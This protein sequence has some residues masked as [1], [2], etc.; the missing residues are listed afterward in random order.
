MRMWKRRVTT[1]KR[2]K[3]RTCTPRPPVIM[4]CAML[5]LD[6][7]LAWTSIPPPGFLELVEF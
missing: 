6:F 2:T 3:K 5:T 7:V 4:F 1:I